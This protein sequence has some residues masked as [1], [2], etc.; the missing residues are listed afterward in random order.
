MPRLQELQVDIVMDFKVAFLT[1]MKETVKPTRFIEG[2][3]VWYKSDHGYQAD[4]GKESS[5]GFK[6]VTSSK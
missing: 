2:A 6:E 5:F 4:I 3:S 1:T